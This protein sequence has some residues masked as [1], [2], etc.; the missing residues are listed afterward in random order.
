VPSNSSSFDFFPSPLTGHH[1]YH[2]NFL[3]WG[4][5]MSLISQPRPFRYAGSISWI[6]LLKVPDL[7]FLNVV[8]HVLH[9]GNNVA[10]K[11][12]TLVGLHKAKEFSRWV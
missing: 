8:G 5:L 3:G 1:G 9:A 7:T 4:K 10:D 12:L 11:A 2:I 6:R